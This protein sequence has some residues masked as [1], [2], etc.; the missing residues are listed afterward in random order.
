MVHTGRLLPLACKE[1]VAAGG[2]MEKCGEVFPAEATKHRKAHHNLGLSSL[3]S[4]VPSLPEHLS[5]YSEPSSASLFA[6]TS[7]PNSASQTPTS[8]T[9]LSPMPSRSSRQSH[10]FAGRGSLMP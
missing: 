3:L 4:P 10:Q 2:A 7:F 9:S 6:I 5:K 1:H 8:P